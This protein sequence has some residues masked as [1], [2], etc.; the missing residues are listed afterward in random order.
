MNKIKIY[1]NRDV[2]D[3]LLLDKQVGIIGYGNQGC[4][5]ALNLRDSGV[6]VVIG[7]RSSS[8]SRVLAKN[9]GF[10]NILSIDSLVE[11]SDVICFMVP[12]EKIPKI[13]S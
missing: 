1:K 10:K 9:D 12:D 8:A 13:F 2:I 5:Q 3:N 6:N 4:A 7:L 11:T